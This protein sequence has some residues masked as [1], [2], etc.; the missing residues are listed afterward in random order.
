MVQVSTY[1]DEIK[2][3]GTLIWYYFICKR[4]VWLMARKI[5]ADQSNELLDIGRFIHENSYSRKCKEVEFE[6]MKFDV[7]ENKNGTVIVEEIKKSSRFIESSRMQCCS[8]S[9]SCIK[10][11]FLPR[12]C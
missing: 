1:S 8:I 12:Y 3:T 4:E 9:M 6:N 11:A 10:K 2:I 5:T 7:I